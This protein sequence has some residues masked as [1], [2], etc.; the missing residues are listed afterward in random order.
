MYMKMSLNVSMPPVTARSQRPAASSSMREV[1]GAERAGAGGVDDAVGAAQV[2]AVGDPAGDDVAQQAGE[3][4]LLPADV[5][6]GDPVGRP[7]SAVRRSTPGVLQA[8]AARS[9]GR[10]APPAG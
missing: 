9:G 3:R 1:E 8:P 7:S 4:V 2:E 10:A 5:G 6:R